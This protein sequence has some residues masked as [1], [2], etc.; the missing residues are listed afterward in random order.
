MNEIFLGKTYRKIENMLKKNNIN[1]MTSNEGKMN[2]IIFALTKT[3]SVSLYFDHEN[4]KCIKFVTNNSPLNDSI[5]IF[6]YGYRQCSCGELH[7]Y[8]G[9]TYNDFLFT[10]FE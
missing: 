4:N 1:F 2:I 3:N 7:I 6:V 10:Q 9:Q 8:G 5:D